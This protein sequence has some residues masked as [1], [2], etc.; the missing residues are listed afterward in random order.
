[1]STCVGSFT[2]SSNLLLL[3]AQADKDVLEQSSI[4]QI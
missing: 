2:R 3:Q 4:L 1:M